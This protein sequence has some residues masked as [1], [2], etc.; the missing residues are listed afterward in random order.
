[1]KKIDKKNMHFQKFEIVSILTYRNEKETMQKHD[2]KE[3]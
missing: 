2:D 3:I 1:M